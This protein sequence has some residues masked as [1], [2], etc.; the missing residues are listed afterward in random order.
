[1]IFVSTGTEKYPFIR[2]VKTI[3]EA[4]GKGLI[5]DEVV[6]QDCAIGSKYKITNCTHYSILPYEEMV[7]WV[8]NCNLYICH[9]GVGSIVTGLKEE[10]ISVVVPRYAKYHEHVDNHQLD[11]TDEFMKRGQIVACYD[12]DD[13]VDRINSYKTYA[14]NLVP[15]YNKSS[16]EFLSFI[17][18]I[19]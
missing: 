14:K 7:R 1:M 11:I 12:G 16:R 18:S 5:R 13:I 2:L 4:K 6:I 19:I 10:K 3:D 15:A 9:A 8:R 17:K